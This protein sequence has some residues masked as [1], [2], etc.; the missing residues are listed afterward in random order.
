[1][2]NKEFYQALGIKKGDALSLRQIIQIAQ[3]RTHRETGE[4]L[5]EVVSDGAAELAEPIQDQGPAPFAVC[6]DQD[7]VEAVYALDPDRQDH[8]T[9]AGLPA[10]KAIEAL[11]GSN[12]VQRSDIERLL[13]DYNRT[14]AKG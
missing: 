14:S 4:G 12:A 13:P 3:M 7:V 1:M 6:S 8:W 5:G 11:V 9:V 2:S 10:M